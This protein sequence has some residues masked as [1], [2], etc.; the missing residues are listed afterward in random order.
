MHEQGHIPLLFAETGTVMSHLSKF[1]VPEIILGS[2]ARWGAVNAIRALDIEHSFIVTDRALVDSPWLSE[3]TSTLAAADSPFTIWVQSSCPAKDHDIAAGT[4]TYLEDHCDGII[5]LGGGSVMDAAKAIGILAGNGGHILDYVG[6]DMTQEPLPPLVMIPTTAGSA[7]DVSGFCTITDTIL[8]RPVTLIGKNLVPDISLTDPDLLTTL[9]RAGIAT[10]GLNILSH[11]I[12]AYLSAG[13]N[14]LTDSVALEAINLANQHIQALYLDSDDVYAREQIVIA[15][16]KAGMACA[17]AGLGLTHALAF[18]LAG[19]LGIH[20][21]LASATLLPHILAF[22]MQAQPKR[23]TRVATVLTDASGASSELLQK[24][25]ER[26]RSLSQTLGIPTSLKE[27][28]ITRSM[29]PDIVDSALRDACM[30]TGP[31]TPSASALH[32]L[33]ESLL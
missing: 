25:G 29:L 22:N 20:C 14:P 9:P 26:L 5:A 31:R 4:R 12:E 30:L 23:V 21:A 15:S 28:G 10:S 8:E 11:S 18:Q 16:V 7:A 1:T 33:L 32:N 24:A 6:I 2:G 13:A 19:R 27:L 17:N 3:L